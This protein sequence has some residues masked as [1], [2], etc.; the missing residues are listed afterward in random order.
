M[1]TLHRQ[2]WGQ[3]NRNQPVLRLIG[4][5]VLFINVDLRH[6]VGSHASQPKE[7]SK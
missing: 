5:T 1:T 6:G 2:N 3:K 4:C 7:I